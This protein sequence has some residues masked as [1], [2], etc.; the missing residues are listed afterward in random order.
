MSKQ[1][2]PGRMDLIFSYWMLLWF[3]L[4]IAKIVP[5]NPKW[6]FIFAVAFTI[7]QMS[8]MIYYKKNAEYILAFLIANTFIKFLPLYFIF[9]DKTTTE[10]IYAMIIALI[11]YFGW[12][13]MNDKNIYKFLIEYITPSDAGRKSFPISNLITNIMAKM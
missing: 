6:L 1:I 11:V 10:D 5:Y 9:G 13:K 12:L 7:L 3:F 2:T 8:I 4:Y